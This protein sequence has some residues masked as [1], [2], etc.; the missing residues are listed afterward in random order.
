MDQRFFWLIWGLL[1]AL[2]TY[3]FGFAVQL[4]AQRVG[5]VDHPD[6][7]RKIHQV[8]TP[9]LGG[10]AIGI[11]LI[12]II[13]FMHPPLQISGMLLGMTILLIGGA[14]DDVFDLHPAV[15]F[16]FPFAASLT[17]VFTGTTVTHVTNFID[18]K[19]FVLPFQ[20]LLTV[21]WL[22]AVTYATKFMDGIDGL[23][24]GQAA[25]GAAVIAGLASSA[26]FFQPSVAIL[27]ILVSGAFLGFLGHNFHPAKQ[28]LGES[29][30]TLAGFLLGVLSILG[31]AKLAT[32]LM[33]LALPLTDAAIVIVGRV[34]RGASPFK[35]DNTHL[36]FKLLKAG[37]HQKHIVFLMW[38]ISLACGI[39]ALF[40]Q[41]GGKL[42][43]VALLLLITTG[44]SFYAGKTISR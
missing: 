38:G 27:A 13:L 40:L 41:T 31:S 9:L 26:A 18:G 39:A 8:P 3:A 19:A 32:G 35:G 24:S 25:I 5:A 17:I 15:Q 44:L 2:M 4:F 42:L 6:G 43:L 29:G 22:L 28:F 11:P 20:E 36:H 23:V 30:S 1:A 37:Y 33:A 7:A 12:L 10:W 14:L 21:V 34:M 16:L